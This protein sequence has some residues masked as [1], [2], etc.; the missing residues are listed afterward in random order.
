MPYKNE[1]AARLKDPSQFTKFSRVNDKF[2]NGID[3]IFGIKNN[4]TQLQAIRFDKSLF[5]TERAH[6]W[7]KKHNYKPIKFEKA[8]SENNNF[9]L[10]FYKK[11]NEEKV[12][13]TKII[14]DINDSDLTDYYLYSDKNNKFLPIT[15]VENTPH[16]SILITLDNGKDFHY[17]PLEDNDT[18][19]TVYDGPSS[20][21]KILDTIK[22]LKESIF[23]AASDEEVKER[24]R[25][26]KIDTFKEW[27]GKNSIRYTEDDKGNVT[28]VIDFKLVGEWGDTPLYFACRENILEIVKLLVS[29]KG[30]VNERRTDGTT[31][32]SFVVKRGFIDLVKL[33]LDNGADVIVKDDQGNTP[34]FYARTQEMKDLLKSHGAKN[35]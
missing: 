22:T 27:M 26:A 25:Q 19:I 30:V 18:S 15:K 1:H 16:Q 13:Y 31:P 3:A 28:D 17:Y 35:G 10:F 14:K 5:T 34:L 32:L 20:K 8:I 2:G 9:K 7:L 23:K 21:E 11:L 24:R 33:L 29:K 4:K 12:T 6:N